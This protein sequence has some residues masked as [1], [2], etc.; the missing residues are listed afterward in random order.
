V[1]LPPVPIYFCHFRDVSEMRIDSVK[2]DVWRDLPHAVL[3]DCATGQ[4]PRLSTT[5]RAFWTRHSLFIRFDCEDD[6]VVATMTRH[7]DPIYEE[8]VVEVFIS[9]TG[10]IETY[11]EFEQSPF[12]V[13]FD[14]LVFNDLQGNVRLD[15]TWNAQ[16]WRSNAIT[17]GENR[18]YV[19]ELPFSN[20][21]GGTPEVGTVWRIN[22]YRVD[23]GTAVNDDLYLAWSPT[24]EQNFHI[25]QRFGMVFFVNLLT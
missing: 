16:D 11:K 23:R 12:N 3:K 6:S 17:K 18:V 13:R 5:A 19:W 4:K 22:F 20:F 9:E 25:P 10:N 2:Q 14:A 21:A 7:D 1:S 8:D 24:G 15:K